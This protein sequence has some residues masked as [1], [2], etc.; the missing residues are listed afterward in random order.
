MIISINIVTGKTQFKGLRSQMGG[1]CAE[2]ILCASALVGTRTA[3]ARRE[4]IASWQHR[5]M[6]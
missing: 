1:G 5:S 6:H 3:M 2:Q 4:T